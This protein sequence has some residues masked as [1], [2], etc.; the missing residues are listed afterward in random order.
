MDGRWWK[1][2]KRFRGDRTDD[3]GL[4]DVHISFTC[5]LVAT[6]DPW[7]YIRHLLQQHLIHAANMSVK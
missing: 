6:L 2:Y 7:H 4:A 5:R 1:R 3:V